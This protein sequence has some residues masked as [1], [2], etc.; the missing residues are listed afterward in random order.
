MRICCEPR[1]TVLSQTCPRRRRRLGLAMDT[2]LALVTVLL[3]ATLAAGADWPCWRGPAGNDTTTEA[4][5]WPRQDWPGDPAWTQ[6]VGE[7]ASSPIVAGG[8]VYVMGWQGGNDSVYSLDAAT[9]KE[10]WRQSYPCPEYPRFHRGDETWYHGVTPT[11]AYDATTGYLFTLSTDGD[12]C[13][14]NDKAG[15]KSVWRMNLHDTYHVPARPEVHG[16]HADH[17]YTTAPLVLGKWLI[18]EVGAP[19]GNLMAFDKLTGHRVWVSQC[20]DARG[21]TGGASP[22]TVSGIPCVAVFTISHLVVVRTD[23]GHE[24]ETLASYPFETQVGQNTVTPAV[25]GDLVILSSGLDMDKTVC[26]RVTLGGITK[27]WEG[28]AATRVCV[29]IITRGRV[30]FAYG[31][32]KCVDLATGETKWGGGMFGEDASCLLTRDDKLIVFGNRKLA[33]VDIAGTAADSYHELALKTGVGAPRSWP[34]V[35]L[36]EGRLFAKDDSG[37]LL[38]FVVGK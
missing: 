33:L 20:Q 16:G 11:P 23:R 6:D 37:K 38:C 22:M 15:G 26:L 10:L 17:G 29:P 13:C 1:T 30:Y 35:T 34:H 19:D 32:L 9:G 27:L 18:V 24:G 12:L 8:R 21:Q 14:W 4:S 31:T 3:M 36:A 2:C 25:D 28:S 7:G 5:G